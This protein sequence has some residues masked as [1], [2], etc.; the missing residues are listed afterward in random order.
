MKNRSALLYLIT[1]SLLCCY[2]GLMAQQKTV[3]GKITDQISK[4]PLPGATVNVKGTSQGVAAD[5][6]GVFSIQAGPSAILVV[7]YMGYGTQEITV[8]NQSSINIALSNS[9]SN[10][11]EIVVVGYGQ[12]KKRDLTGS[13]VSIK[14]DEAVKVPAGNAIEALQGKIPGA[15]IYRDNG[16]AGGGSNFRIRGTRSI[17]NP[18]ASNNVLYIVDGVQGFTMSDIDPNDIQSVD[19]LKDA[20]STAI[21]GSRGANGVVII[22][23]K[24]GATGKPKLTFSSYA[25]VS[26]VSKYGRMKTG[27]E[28]IA[29]KREAYR[30]VGT[31]ASPADD[32]KIFNPQELNAI[33]NQQYINWP[34]LLLH[35]GAQQNY[36]VGVSGGTERTK[37]YFSAGYYHEKGILKMDGYKR[38]STRFNIDQTINNWLKVGISS[39]FAYIDNDTRRDPFNQ[40]TKALPLGLPFDS[41]GNIVVYPVGGTQMSPLSDEQPGQWDANTKTQRFSGAAYVELTPLKDLNIRSTFTTT[42]SGTT[43]GQFYGKSTIIGNNATSQAMINNS[44]FSFISWETQANYHKEVK[45]HSLDVTGVVSYNQTVNTSNYALG[46][47]QTFPSQSWYNLA[48]ATQSPQYGSGYNKFALLSFTGRINYSYLGRY[49]LTLTGRSDGSSKLAPGHK[50][51]FFPSV[52]AGWRI[53]DES[54]MK[55][56]GIFSDLKLRAS[57]G[58]SGNDVIAPYA[59]Q[60]S[61]SVIP[62]TYDEANQVAA[63]GINAQIANPNLSWELTATTDIGLDFSILKDRINGSVDYYDART[64]D[65]IFPYTLPS[66]TGV[67]TINRNVGKT[68]NKGV[69]VSLTTN[70]I[71]T[72]AFRW[73][74]NI[75]WARNK[76]EITE[77]PNGNVISSD[78]RQSLILG[79]SPTIYYD[80]KKLGI[81]QLGEEAEA[82]K[83][84]AKPG[85]I[86]I[87]D[88]SGPDGKPDGKI[89]A[90]DRTIIGT[91]VPKWTGGISNSFSYK[92]FDLDIQIIARIGQWMSSDYYAKYYRN[93]SQNGSAMD[94]WTPE[95][96]TNAYPRPSATGSS[97]YITTLTEYQ[98]SYAKLRN[99]TLG[100][101][102]P[103]TFTNRAKIERVRIYVSGKNLAFIAK[104]KDFDPESEGIIDQPLSKLYV[105]GL[106]V[107]F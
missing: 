32:D 69:E 35:H 2:T 29:F 71:V 106:N 76:E 17:A 64:Y 90:A 81:W 63:Y 3:T 107:T 28:Y 16:Y 72:S 54:F 89:T 18:G 21:Y 105:A 100:Y 26:D 25:G 61:L 101:T 4:Q 95:N 59:T 104:N 42:Q 51:A 82:E 45:D 102:L 37:I 10:V 56:Q 30:A 6:N 31:W 85:D 7:S 47:N 80:Y 55:Q 98:N 22:T 33:Q 39:Q 62:F 48:G 15:D 92:N 50:W 70:N 20:S 99:V 96:P 23:T 88:I 57:W 93:G 103:K 53:S 52:A 8:G 60:N 67:G 40:A 94:Y 79:Q 77:L 24:R 13:V 84:Q 12:V 36:Q 43:A 91:R 44:S 19:V 49:L 68:R 73:S 97:S 34:D 38:Y 27:P 66:S 74:T 75:S 78:Y 41:A 5:V 87:A 46:K 9:I 86:K 83:Y 65:L 1:L 14:G 11:N 58:I